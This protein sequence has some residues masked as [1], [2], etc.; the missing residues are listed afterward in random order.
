MNTRTQPDLDLPLLEETC[1]ATV[2]TL[3]EKYLL[4]LGW[5]FAAFNSVRVLAYLPTIWAIHSS[6]D[7]SQHSLWTWI[8][9]LGANLTM[10]AWLY[11]NNA[12]RVNKAIV[13]NTCNACM[14]L[15]VTILIVVH[16]L[17]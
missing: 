3:R 7:S 9:W 8:T 13:V 12:N 5:A 6:G 17:G 10:A 16:R 1:H 4:V 11:E 15:G 2:R 14:C